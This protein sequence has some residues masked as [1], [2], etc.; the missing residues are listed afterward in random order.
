MEYMYVQTFYR[1]GDN[2]GALKHTT[3]IFALSDHILNREWRFIVDQ[4]QTNYHDRPIV[5]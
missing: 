2:L 4:V 1:V 5:L 3:T